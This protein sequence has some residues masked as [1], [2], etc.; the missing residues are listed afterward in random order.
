MDKGGPPSFMIEGIERWRK[1]DID[2]FLDNFLSGVSPSC[3][4]RIAGHNPFGSLLRGHDGVRSFFKRMFERSNKTFRAEPIEWL[5]S[6]DHVAI[7]LHVTAET[8]EGPVDVGVVHFATIGADGKL[9]KN[10]FL[11]SDV[12]MH[13]R[14][15]H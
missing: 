9:D 5:G 12:S 15:L 8:P 3:T 7:F 14:L 6:K 1:G 4:W 11:P 2:G 10:W 13:D